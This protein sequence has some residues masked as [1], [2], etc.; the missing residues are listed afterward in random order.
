VAL[1]RG[2]GWT[3]VDS[4][5]AAVES[6][7]FSAQLLISL[8]LLVSVNPW[9]AS[10]VPAAAVPLW[11]NRIG[12]RR[13]ARIELA[14]AEPLRMQRHLFDMCTRPSA[15][16]EIRISG[17]GTELINRQSANWREMMRLR[18]RARMTSA[19]FAVAGWGAFT[20]GYIVG[21][22]FIARLVADGH[23]TV[24]DMVMSVTLASQLRSQVENFVN[25]S[26]QALESNSVIEPYLW[27]REFESRA[28]GS[29]TGEVAAVLREGVVLKDV[30][31]TYP[32]A[33]RPALRGISAHLPAG[34]VVAIV[35]EYG[36]GKSTLVKL[37]AKMYQPDGGAILVDGVNLS[38]LDTQA[39]RENLA[40]AFQDFGRY[41]TTVKEAVGLGDPDRVEDDDAVRQAIG[42]ADAD[43][44][45]SR[46]PNGLQTRL[47][48]VF[49]GV[50]LSEGQWQKI[51]LAR[52][53]MRPGPLL[54]ILDE[55]TASLDAPSEHEI[56]VGYARRARALAV[57]SGAVT[58]IVS[59]RFSTI[60]MADHILVMSD[61]RITEAGDHRTL[62][63]KEGLYA[64]LYR[65]HEKAYADRP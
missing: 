17:S 63:E 12:R 28:M 9:L 29:G 57:K 56:F 51:A 54:F 49:D 14:A 39:W 21:L 35:G 7:A 42:E 43:V 2:Q 37:L 45:V 18:F 1:V 53:C 59:H 33:R 24:G 5:W 52:A 4:A 22:A 32:G 8:I 62:M 44:V 30:E 16:K 15:A 11:L 55:P 47:G 13:A 40:A 41:Q 20:A 26:G 10:L 60:A 6:V 25:R 23:G 34:S 36:S 31:F 38:E 58:V 64:E 27:L 61:G 46:L 19:L 48:P 65:I 50:D 3:I